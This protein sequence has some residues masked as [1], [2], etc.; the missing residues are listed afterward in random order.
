MSKIL[1]VVESPGKIKKLQAILGDKYLVMASIGHILD[2]DPKKM[3]VDLEHNFEPT[4]KI[5]SNNKSDKEPVVKDLRKAASKAADVLLAADEDREGEMIA[6]SVANVLGLD[7][8]KAKRIT[9]NSITKTELEKAI[10]SPRTIDMNLVDAQKS[11][12]IL[13][14]IIGFEISPILWKSI[15]ASLSAGRVQSVVTRLLIDKELEIKDFFQ[16]GE[17][18]YFK[19]TGCFQV[20]KSK[21]LLANLFAK[22]AKKE[23]NAIKFERAKLE[24]ESQ[25]RNLIKLF[26]KSGYTIKDIIEK[27]SLR[28]PSPPFTTSTLVQEA[29]RKLGYTV[30]RTNSAAQK[31]YEAGYITYMRTDS[32]SL[33]VDA[34]EN[35]KKFVQ[36]KY[37]KE[38]HRLI[39]Y[40]AK[41]KNTQEAHE[42]CRPTDVFV[43]NI[44]AETKNKIG[45]DE[46][47]LY[48]LIWKRA[49]ASQMQP[50]S[51]KLTDIVIDADK[52]A[53]YSF[54]SQISNINFSGFLLVYNLKNIEKEEVKDA[55]ESE[56]LDEDT[57]VDIKLPKIGTKLDVDN[58]MSE[59]EYQK[60]PTRYN[61]A[62]LV[63]KLDPKNLNIGRPSTYGAIINTIQERGYVKIDNI[64]G[65]E[66]DS[67]VMKWD[68]GN[69]L[70]EDIKKVI[71]GKENNKLIPTSLGTLVTDFLIKNFPDI[72]D[73]KFTSSMEESLDNIAEGKKVW[74]KILDNFYKKFHPVVQKLLESKT[75]V[76]SDMTRVLGNHPTLGFEIAATIARFGP[77]IKMC[78]TKSKCVYAPIKEPLTRDTITLADAVK[79]LEYPKN[80]GKHEGME[81]TLNKGKH[82]LYLKWGNVKASL[83][84]LP[85]TIKIK[86]KEKITL[87][88]AISVIKEKRKNLLWEKIDGKIIY[89]ILLGPYGNYIDVNDT[90]KKIKKKNLRVPVKDI[91]DKDIKNLTLEKVHELIKIGLE[92]K[93]NRFKKKDKTD[94]TDKTDKI[95]K[96]G[97]PGKPDKTDKTDKIDKTGK[98]DKTDKVVKSVKKD[99]SDK[100]EKKASKQ[101]RTKVKVTKKKKN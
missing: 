53:N 81:I 31:L 83:E 94:K 70:K 79:L 98:P 14:R 2:L 20:N 38:F 101:S 10:K 1:V 5:I 34:L 33:S 89:S 43:E 17:S 29:S 64:E 91:E 6:W 77:V 57:I 42:A 18:N 76:K 69:K 63:N 87:E 39:N 67:L 24:T 96:T 30:K 74:T 61:E 9:F 3:S 13:D 75:T 95:D 97:K 88:E 28:Y 93:A 52:V 12:R 19:F 73:Y 82:G 15:G 36:S 72:V 45:N 35:I 58:I 47:K 59:Q 46:I 80:V 16:Q 40:E 23:K 85:E 68:G 25:A 56:E 78:S 26:M 8:K 7:M 32:V 4:Y 11:R 44:N 54:I 55:D 92:N 65:I 41:T 60:P 84:N 62:S 21:K 49:V 90:G 99:K 50:A 66:K 37:G 71:I 86:D 100:P 27:D 48:N 51:I 22:I